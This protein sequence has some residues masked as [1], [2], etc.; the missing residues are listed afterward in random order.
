VRFAVVPKH[1]LVLSPTVIDKN[2]ERWVREW[3]DLVVR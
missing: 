3:T 2:R 1:P